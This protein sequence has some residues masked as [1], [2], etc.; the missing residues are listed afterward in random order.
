MPNPLPPAL[1]LI[2]PVL[3]D[4]QGRARARTLLFI[5]GVGPDVVQQNV[6]DLNA[7][8]GA[9]S[10]GVA[11][12][13]DLVSKARTAMSASS[14]RIARQHVI[15]KAILR[16]LCEPGP[17]N[18]G[19]QLMRHDLLNGTA[20]PNGP[21]GVGYVRNF[22]KI[23]SQATE[24]LWQRTE[25]A[26]PQA[27]DAAISHAVLGDPGLLCVLRDVIALHYV[28]NPQAL[29]VHEQTFAEVFHNVADALTETPAAAEA[30]RRRYGLEVA[31]P[32]ARRLGAEELL[33]AVKHMF[34]QGA[35]F[36]VRV[37][38]LFETVQDRFRDSG[39]E[40]LEPAD[41]GTEFLIGDTPALPVEFATGRAGVRA[42]ITLGAA[43]TV[44]LPLTPR[45]LV[46]LGPVTATKQVPPEFVEHVN[47]VQ[48]QS[49]QR[50]VH[51]RLTAGFGA[52]IEAWRATPTP[53]FTGPLSASLK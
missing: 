32:Q 31:G 2:L 14:P 21:G 46:S 34:A 6:P 36:R 15:S 23:D 25:N 48:V 49:A 10:P 17:G 33:A 11:G 13:A 22:V 50:Y 1:K 30:F 37:Q 52:A 41:P 43:N 24:G 18:A 7:A 20:R 40:I 44:M 9:S 4:D 53:P 51:H 42:G 35:L 16:R 27:I 28:R 5:A 19:L 8:L 3:A 47:H 38:D 29:E 39:V 26:L 12:L 45:L